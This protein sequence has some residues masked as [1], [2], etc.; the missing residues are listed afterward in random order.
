MDKAVT[1]EAIR[2]SRIVAIIREN[3]PDIALNAAMACCESGITCIEV[4]LT[5]P[6]GLHVIERLAKVAN[7]T[8]GAGTVLDAQTAASAIHAGATFLLSPAVVP[9]M[10]RACSKYGVVSVPGAFTATETLSALEAGAD[11]VKIFPAKTGGPD[12]IASLAAPF[13]QAVFMPS[14][15]VS[16][17][18]LDQ[19]FVR[20]VIAVGVGGYLTADAASGDYAAVREKA[21]R[22]V[23]AAHTLKLG[24]A[25]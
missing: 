15:G 24:P 6:R 10:I 20:G 25:R 12:Y 5:T 21:R 23:A 14:G 19:W 7:L 1:L 18:N 3:D 16:S 8:V 4:A 2:S 11:I 13:P 9:E 22:L 17:E